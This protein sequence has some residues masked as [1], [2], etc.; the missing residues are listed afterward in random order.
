M[1]INYQVNVIRNW[2]SYELLDNIVGEV[3]PRN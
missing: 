1:K 2:M 3:I